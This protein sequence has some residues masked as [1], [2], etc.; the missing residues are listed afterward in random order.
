MKNAGVEYFPNLG[1]VHT[2]DAVHILVPFDYLA[3]EIQNND[4]LERTKKEIVSARNK[5]K[6]IIMVAHAV[7]SWAMHGKPSQSGES[8]I[9]EQNLQR[10]ISI[11]KL[12][13]PCDQIDTATLIGLYKPPWPC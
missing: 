12:I 3:S 11:L 9:T 7:P 6:T 1:T 13:I 2:E 4:L 10:L 8:L 5:N